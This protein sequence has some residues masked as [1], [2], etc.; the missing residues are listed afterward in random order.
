[1]YF[2][3]KI[4]EVSTFRSMKDG[5]TGNT[6]GTIEEDVRRRDFSLNALFYDPLKQIVVDYVGG[7]KDIQ[8][9]LIRPII[10]LPS[11]FTDD[12]VRMI[13]AVKYAAVSGFTLPFFLR[14][15][16]RKHGGLLADVS[17]SRLTEEILKI[18]NSPHVREI[19]EALDSLGLYRYLQPRASDLFKTARGFR[20]RYM[21]TLGSPGKGDPGA[22]PGKALSALI[23]DFLEDNADWDGK[24]GAPREPA[25]IA[26]RE[27]VLSLTERYKNVFRLARKF[28]LPMNP[29]RVELDAAIR[30]LFAEHG[31]ALKKIRFSERSFRR[32]PL[33]GAGSRRG[34]G[35]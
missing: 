18:I 34:P 27:P 21:K 10:A 4:F 16:I 33:S 14:W 8:K 3:A 30:L 31:I 7:M 23:Q 20:A 11:I 29:P 24:Y 28:I 12:P 13:R 19:V 9:R 26:P 15:R 32:A 22:L 17:P 25:Q 1:V 5:P 2:G 6:F 35:R